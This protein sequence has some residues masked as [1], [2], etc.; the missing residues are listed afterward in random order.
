MFITYN[1][2]DLRTGKNY[3]IDNMGQDTA[4]TKLFFETI[5][6]V[7]ARIIFIVQKKIEKINPSNTNKRVSLTIL[8]SSEATAILWNCSKLFA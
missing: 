6:T 8:M 3:L 4:F 5:Q 7:A 1:E 2:R